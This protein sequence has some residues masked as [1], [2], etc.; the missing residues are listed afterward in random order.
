VTEP[1]ERANEQ[2]E[3]LCRETIE[4]KSFRSTAATTC[5]RFVVHIESVPA[6]NRARPTVCA[7][8]R[9]QQETSPCHGLSCVSPVHHAPVRNAT[10]LTNCNS[11]IS[12]T[13]NRSIGTGG[14]VRA[15]R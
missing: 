13:A 2:C 7:R 15:L 4:R 14:N 6:A 8:L 9:V 12:N 3:P 11:G 10:D 1:T 5:G